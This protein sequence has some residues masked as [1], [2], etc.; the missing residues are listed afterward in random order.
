[1]YALLKKGGIQHGMV[2]SELAAKDSTNGTPDRTTWHFLCD[3]D[4][5]QP[6]TYHRMPEILLA[7]SLVVVRQFRG[8]GNQRAPH[9]LPRR[10]TTLTTA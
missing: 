4:A 7:H 8:F 10:G 2:S 5:L 6:T 3:I 1:M 9:V